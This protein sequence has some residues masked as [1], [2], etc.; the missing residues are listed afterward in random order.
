M[1]KKDKPRFFPRVDWMRIKKFQ[2]CTEVV[3]MFQNYCITRNTTLVI[4]FN[5]SECV[6]KIR[7][8]KGFNWILM[9]IIFMEMI[10]KMFHS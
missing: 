3:S 4:F 2:G 1:R 5:I 7:N 6:H 9:K 8:S 10:K